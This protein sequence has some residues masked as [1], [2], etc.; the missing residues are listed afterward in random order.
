MNIQAAVVGFGIIIA[1]ICVCLLTI[2]FLQKEKTRRKKIE[3]AFNAQADYIKRLENRVKLLES[4]AR[5]KET[6]RR[7]ADE[8]IDTL[9][10]GDAVTNALDVLQNNA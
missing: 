8:K 7:E 10:T 3:D 1:L 4:E 9:H 6:N 2:V 5:I